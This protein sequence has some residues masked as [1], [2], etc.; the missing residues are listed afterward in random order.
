MLKMQTWK[1]LL[2]QIRRVGFG[3]V[4]F[5]YVLAGVVRLVVLRFVKFSLV[6]AGVVRCGLACCVVLGLR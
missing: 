1:K 6:L 3:C 2:R 5:R 4:L